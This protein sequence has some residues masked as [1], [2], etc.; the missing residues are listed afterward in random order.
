[1]HALAPRA[2]RTLINRRMNADLRLLSIYPAGMECM[3]GQVHDRAKLEEI[4][5]EQQTN[6]ESGSVARAVFRARGSAG[7]AEGVAVFRRGRLASQPTKLVLG[8]AGLNPTLQYMWSIVPGG[9]ADCVDGRYLV[10]TP[11]EFSEG[12][13]DLAAKH[14]LLRPMARV[15]SVGTTSVV[16]RVVYDRQLRFSS[17]KGILGG[18]LILGPPHQ[19]LHNSV[20]AAIDLVDDHSSDNSV[21][22]GVCIFDVDM[23]LTCGG[24]CASPECEFADSVAG[25]ACLDTAVTSGYRSGYPLRFNVR[26][27]EAVLEWCAARQ[28]VPAIATHGSRAEI[29][30]VGNCSVSKMNYVKRL[31][32]IDNAVLCQDVRDLMSTGMGTRCVYGGSAWAE[33]GQTEKVSKDHHI[34]A[35]LRS[36]VLPRERH[37][38]EQQLEDGHVMELAA[39]AE[40]KV[41]FFDDGLANQ[42]DVLQAVD[43]YGLGLAD[44]PGMSVRAT[45]PNTDTLAS[46]GGW[47]NP[48][49]CGLVEEELEGLEVAAANG[50]T[51]HAR[52]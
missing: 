9:A 18:A 22:H 33:G 12:H 29:D 37:Q 3:W 44:Y 35:I 36:F 10:G 45:F 47:G 14:G 1:M 8:V 4:E 43:S 6:Y 24:D 41:M 11:K 52:P 16:A 48:N 32:G 51:L 17:S 31:L 50:W 39:A 2:H 26:G 21:A 7:G 23:T 40:F 49:S 5:E 15:R 19:E 42:Q 27:T 28:L 25:E 30:H 13:I 34:R 38:Y 20:C 46:R